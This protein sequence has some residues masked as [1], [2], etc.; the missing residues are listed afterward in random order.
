MKSESNH[1]WTEAQLAYLNEH[2]WD[3]GTAWIV[4]FRRKFNRWANDLTDNAIRNRRQHLRRP[5]LARA[6]RERRKVRRLFPF[7]AV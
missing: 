4:G 2:L 3:E 1:K 6:Q 7:A 5:E